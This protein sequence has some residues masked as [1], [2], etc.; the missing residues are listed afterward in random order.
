MPSKKRYKFTQKDFEELWNRT[1]QLIKSKA[2]KY[3][4]EMDLIADKI[5]IPL[6]IQ[7]MEKYMEQINNARAN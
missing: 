5:D 2:W 7:D 6:M 1:F 4:I 3:A